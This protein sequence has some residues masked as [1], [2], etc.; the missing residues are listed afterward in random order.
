[1]VCCRDSTASSFVA[2][3]RD[4]VFAHFNAV[5]IKVTVVCGTDSLACQDEFFVNTPLDIKGNDEHAL[6]FALHL[7]RLPEIMDTPSYH[8]FFSTSPYWGI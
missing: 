2:K 7:S 8:L 4:E 3:V 5:A 1:M 6:D